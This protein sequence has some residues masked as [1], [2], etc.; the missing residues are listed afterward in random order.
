MKISYKLILSFLIIVLLSVGSVG[1][2]SFNVAKNNM[3]KE[4]LNKLEAVGVLKKDVIISYFT[5]LKEEIESTSVFFNIKLNLPIMNEYLNDQLNPKWIQSLQ[6][7]DVQL[8]VM[9]EKKKAIDDIMLTNKDGIIVYA[10]SPLHFNID[11]GKRLVNEEAYVNGKEKVYLTDIFYNSVTKENSQL[12]AGPIL[13]EQGNLMGLVVFELNVETINQLFEERAGLGETGETYIVAND[14]LMRSQSRFI[15]ESTILKQKVDTDSVKFGL[16][17][18]S[19][20]HT[21]LDYRRIPVLS[22]YSQGGLK[23]LFGLNYEWVIISEIDVE[24]A[25]SSIY[26]LRNQILLIGLIIALMSIMFG[27]YLSR[28]ISTPI[29]QLTKTIEDIS[30]GKLDTE[31]KGKERKDEIGDLAR[32]FERTIVSLKL[33]MKKTGKVTPFEEPKKKPEEKIKSAFKI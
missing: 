8:T 30:M 21:I 7:L 33:A 10:S 23:E 16:E 4:A 22:Y 6:M 29:Q 11:V 3:E 31:I 24:E 17:G 27:L 15:K 5:L 28:F 9:T 26:H 13:D 18:K 14:L 2:L 19:G 1:F 20:T 25:F 32:A 12:I